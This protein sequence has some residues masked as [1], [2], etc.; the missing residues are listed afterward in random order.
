MVEF[1]TGLVVGKL[2]A[3][4]GELALK[5]FNAAVEVGIDG[6]VLGQRRRELE[7]AAAQAMV[8]AVHGVIPF[9]DGRARWCP[10]G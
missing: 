10:P 6:V 8:G 5:F 9:V 1:L 4:F 2:E 3:E 7:D